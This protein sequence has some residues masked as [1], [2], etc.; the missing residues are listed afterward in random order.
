MGPGS[1]I[2][3]ETHRLS[4]WIAWRVFVFGI[5]FPAWTIEQMEQELRES[6]PRHDMQRR[7]V[8]AWP[9]APTAWAFGQLARCEYRSYVCRG[10]C[11]FT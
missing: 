2:D 5:G 8:V 7:E 3:K 11:S 10:V 6:D 1:G 4:Q 9:E